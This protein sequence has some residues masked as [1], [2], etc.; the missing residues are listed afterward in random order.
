MMKN[1]LTV[2]ALTIGMASTAASALTPAPLQA[3]P[4]LDITRYEGKWFEIARLPNSFQ[5]DCMGSVTAQYEPLPNGTIGVV[6]S[7]RQADGTID[8]T[9]GVARP[10]RADPTATAKLQV[11]FAPAWLSW[12]PFVWGPYWV[13]VL[14]PDYRYAVVSEPDRKY[15]WILSR[16]PIMEVATYDALLSRV[17]AMGF[18]TS[19]LIKTIQP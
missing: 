6:N 13:V 9:S 12:V 1:A 8:H 14:D 3:V 17:A 7:C 5:R 19:Q 16:T 10:D 18:D 11:R 4:V 2:I 15:L